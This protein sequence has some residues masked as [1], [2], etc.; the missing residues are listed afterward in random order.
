MSD[1]GIFLAENDVG[2]FRNHRAYK[3][4]RGISIR[5]LRHVW[6]SKELRPAVVLFISHFVKRLGRNMK[7]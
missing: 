6:L 7:G 1:L 4:V 3:V 5:M 2:S